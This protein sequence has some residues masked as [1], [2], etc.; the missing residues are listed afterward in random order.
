M[1]SLDHTM[2]L[3]CWASGNRSTSTS[4]P[5]MGVR[6]I[7]NAANAEDPSWSADGTWLLV[8][9]APNHKLPSPY[10]N[11]GLWKIRVDGSESTRLLNERVASARWSPDGRWL[12]YIP[13]PSRDQIVRASPDGTNPVTIA[14][15][16][17]NPVDPHT[18]E[19]RRRFA[20]FSSSLHVRW[21]RWPATSDQ[22]DRKSGLRLT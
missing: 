19:I 8:H 10:G 15:S 16:A 17:S 1:L 22:P 21:Y 6:A 5:G 13:L 20:N 3:Q 4:R 7:T 14:N 11:V 12:A 18:H 2:R 9:M